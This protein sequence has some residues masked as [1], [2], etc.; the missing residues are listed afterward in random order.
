MSY[1]KWKA[2]E[3]WH[4]AFQWLLAILPERVIV[5]PWATPLSHVE[6]VMEITQFTQ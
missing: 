1:I 5:M 6:T 3:T 2:A 4:N